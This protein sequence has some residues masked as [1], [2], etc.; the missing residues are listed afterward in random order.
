MIAG[1]EGR[2]HAEGPIAVA[3]QH[4]NA[5]ITVGHHEVDLPIAIDVVHRQAFR[6]S[7]A[8]G[9]AGTGSV[10]HRRPEGPIAVAQQY[11]DGVGTS[12][13][14]CQVVLA[15][16]VE[17]AHDDGPGK[18][19]NSVRGRHSRQER[20]IA[21]AQKHRD[22]VGINQVVL[23]KIGYDQIEVPVAI[24][25]ANGYGPGILANVERLREHE[26]PIAVAQQYR[27]GVGLIVGRRQV[28]LPIAVEIPHGHHGTVAPRHGIRRRPEAPIAVAQQ[29]RN[30]V[31]STVAHRQ[32]ENAIPVEVSHCHRPGKRPNSVARGRRRPK[33]P[34]QV[35]QQHRDGVGALVGYGQVVLAIPVEVAHG[36]GCRIRP[37][38]I[39]SGRCRG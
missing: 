13:G 19:A 33:S 15:I 4:R 17:V 22:C 38:R 34:I 1:T 9:V 29:H 10:A 24:E 30:G 16:L 23:I 31:G 14:H 18:T 32:V 35:A 2:L 37:R 3:Q 39:I 28:G 12:V 8:Q 26:G 25:V 27:D 21:L 36:D 6:I 11:R 7:V 20:P 5:R